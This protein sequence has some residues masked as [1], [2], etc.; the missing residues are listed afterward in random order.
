M[1]GDRHALE[2]RRH[3]ARGREPLAV[4]ARGEEVGEIP[5][6][7]RHLHRGFAHRHKMWLDLL[8]LVAFG[9]EEVAKP[10]A[11]GGRRAIAERH[12]RVERRPSRRDRGFLGKAGEQPGFLG[13]GEIENLVAD[14]DPASAA[15]V[16]SSLE[17]AEGKV[18]QREIGARE[19]GRLDEAATCRIMRRVCLEHGAFLSRL[20]GAAVANA[21]APRLS[22]RAPKRR[23]RRAIG[24]PD[25]R[26]GSRDAWRRRRPR[27][28][29]G[30]R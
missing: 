20:R 23:R 27:P 10:R 14:R 28:P 11:Q 16:L 22:V 26:T 30:S 3:L 18:L 13:S 24:P 5:D 19:I 15:L 4:E 12:Q 29:P 9:I 7:D 25:L 6:R 1:I 8:A 21:P 2:A 17:D